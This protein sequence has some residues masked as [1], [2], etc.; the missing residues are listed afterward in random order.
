MT[1]NDLRNELVDA[2]NLARERLAD[3]R[4]DEGRII[5]LAQAE[6]R[7]AVLDSLV[8]TR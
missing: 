2:V 3:D 7:L 8:E 5:S 6:Q 1:R 4:G